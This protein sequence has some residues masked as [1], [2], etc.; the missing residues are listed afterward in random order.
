MTEGEAANASSRLRTDI[1]TGKGGG[2]ILKGK[3]LKPG[4]NRYVVK[5]VEEKTWNEEIGAQMCLVLEG[6]MYLPLNRTRK[7]ALAQFVNDYP[8]AVGKTVVLSPFPTTNPNSGEATTGV[9]LVAVE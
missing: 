2:D 6:G 7:V 8:D 5:A 4:L 3:S 1:E 9:S